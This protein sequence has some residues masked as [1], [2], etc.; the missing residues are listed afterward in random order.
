MEAIKI[1][2]ENLD[3]TVETDYDELRH[4]DAIL[5]DWLYYLEENDPNNFDYMA[6]V[7]YAIDIIKGT[8]CILEQNIVS[9]DGYTAKSYGKS[10]LVIFNEDGEKMHSG[11]Y[12]GKGTKDEL[13]EQIDLYIA[14]KEDIENARKRLYSKI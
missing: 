6:E 13:E 14:L 4:I 8:G 3:V 12:Y 9:K 1:N 11:S 7:L 10:S 2:H 5:N